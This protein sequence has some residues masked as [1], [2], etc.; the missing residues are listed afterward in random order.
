MDNNQAAFTLSHVSFSYGKKQLFSDLSLS[1]PEGKITTLIG[2]NG[3]G[4][5][6]LFNLMTKKLKAST[7]NYSFA[8]GQRFTIALI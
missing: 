1:I 6:T 5:T 8:R 7:R 2:A 4:K 3:S